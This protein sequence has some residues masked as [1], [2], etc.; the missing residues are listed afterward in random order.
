LNHHSKPSE[1]KIDPETL[2]LWRSAQ[3]EFIRQYP[4]EVY[5]RHFRHLRLVS[6]E[7]GTLTVA[8]VDKQS[9]E[10]LALRLDKSLR[11]TLKRLAGRDVEVK[12]EVTNGKQT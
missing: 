6:T 7:N 12:Y 9:R 3:D 5:D 2:S 8:A 11:R 4:R 1:E 10:W